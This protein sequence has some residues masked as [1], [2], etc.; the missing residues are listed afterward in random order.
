MARVCSPAGF[1]QGRFTKRFMVAIA[2]LRLDNATG[3]LEANAGNPIILG[4]E[5]ESEGGSDAKMQEVFLHSADPPP[6]EVGSEAKFMPLPIKNP[7]HTP[8]TGAIHKPNAEGGGKSFSGQQFASPSSITRFE[9]ECMA[10][11]MPCVVGLLLLDSPSPLTTQMAS[12]P[13][14]GPSPTQKDHHASRRLISSACPLYTPEAVK[15]DDEPRG[16]I[17]SL[18]TGDKRAGQI[19]GVGDEKENLAHERGI[20]SMLED[21]SHIHGSS[22]KRAINTVAN[23]F[24]TDPNL[25]HGSRS[26]DQ[27]QLGDESIISGK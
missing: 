27:Q 24:G 21:G 3:I 8:R 26:G 15:T 12:S 4:S 14:Y 7:L 19:F 16:I 10:R 5:T 25:A 13:A 2:A 22:K 17:A 20:G 18:P 9:T 11:L 1:I 6:T 23:C